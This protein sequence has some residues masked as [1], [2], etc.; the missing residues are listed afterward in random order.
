MKIKKLLNLSILTLFITSNAYAGVTTGAPS[1]TLT[2][3]AN[4]MNFTSTTNNNINPSVTS[5]QTSR[6]MNTTTLIENV[7]K[8]A[9]EAGL[10]IDQAAIDILLNNEEESGDLF[11]KIEDAKD[12]IGDDIYSE[13]KK[14]TLDSQ[15][16]VY[17]DADWM[18]LGKVSGVSSVTG[19]SYS[20]D[21]NFF[22]VS[23][24]Q[25][26]KTATY[27]NLATNEISAKI[28]TRVT[29]VGSSTAEG[30]FFTGVAA[31][32]KF[33]AVGSTVRRFNSDGSNT[34][35][36]WHG[37]QTSMVK[38]A[39]ELVD[40][41]DGEA[42][43]LENQMDAYNNNFVG[44]ESAV[45]VTAK[46]LITDSALSGTVAVEAGHCADACTEQAF[47]ESV[48]RW[49]ASTTLVAEEWDGTSPTD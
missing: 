20:T 28:W 31:L 25:Q 23:G 43:T 17:K 12:N 1:T 2:Q 30:S 27:V 39:T 14:P 11:S 38:N 22:N 49:E 34:W 46:A 9:D 4:S 26:A 47:V 35:D 42:S 41:W 5:S 32:E 13:D 37:T 16:I 18:D 6:A 3:V 29:R 48:E 8:A 24:T 10:D 36:N 21:N 44:S 40:T 15:T 7:T 33:P 45:F 19:L